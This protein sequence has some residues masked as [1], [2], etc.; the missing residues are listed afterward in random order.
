MLNNVFKKEIMDEFRK[1]EGKM[2]VNFLPYLHKEKL[3][4]GCR[5][6]ALLYNRGTVPIII[7]KDKTSI[8]KGL[9]KV[10]IKKTLA[11]LN[12]F[13]VFDTTFIES[14]EISHEK[15]L[16]ITY[17]L[18]EKNLELDVAAIEFLHSVALYA[19]AFYKVINTV[20]LVIINTQTAAE[21]FIDFKF[22]VA[23]DDDYVTIEYK[24]PISEEE[25]EHKVDIIHLKLELS[26]TKNNGIKPK[27]NFHCKNCDFKENCF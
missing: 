26:R 15:K 2:K 23:D 8:L 14:Y 1:M 18:V 4:F 10:Q 22:K 27:T 12:D 3:E 9:K 6:K 25:I 17:E 5:T 24:D 11:P 13:K 21:A 20:R 19:F 16:L 7:F